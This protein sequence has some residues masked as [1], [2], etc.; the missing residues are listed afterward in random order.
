M[1]SECNWSAGE[2]RGEDRR[3]FTGHSE[4]QAKNPKG[5]RPKIPRAAQSFFQEAKL[6][7]EV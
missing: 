7:V 5:N 3:N 6:L 2:L 1:V 4:Q